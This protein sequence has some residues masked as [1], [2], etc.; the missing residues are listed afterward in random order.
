[1]TNKIIAGVVAAAALLFGAWMF[2]RES[3]VSFGTAFPNVIP[4]MQAEGFFG[5]V[6]IGDNLTE[7][8]F[9]DSVKTG[10]CALT[11]PSGTIVAG[12]LQN[13]EC[14]SGTDGTIDAL[15]GV[16]A[17]SACFLTRSASS[18][19]TLAVLGAAAS[20]SATV[21]GGSIIATVL[22]VSTTTDHTWSSHSTSTSMW[23]Y[24]CID[25]A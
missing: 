8:T 17:D 25:P 24:T 9:I 23:A 4:N 5:G 12:N 20:S 13:V 6:L 3:P 21:A 2:V 16:T 14:S 18:T 19:M 11:V 1:M 15:P 10:T 22:N 7:A